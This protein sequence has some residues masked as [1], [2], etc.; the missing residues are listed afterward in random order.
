[1][2]PRQT[3]CLP[4][5]QLCGAWKTPSIRR[6]IFPV[7]RNSAQCKVNIS[8]APVPENLVTYYPQYIGRRGWLTQQDAENTYLTHKDLTVQ[9]L[10][11][12]NADCLAFQED[13]LQGVYSLAELSGA[14]AATAVAT[15]T[16]RP[17]PGDF[18]CQGALPPLS[19][20]GRPGADHHRRSLA[21]QR[22]AR[23]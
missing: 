21:A 9:L 20:A 3:L 15:P 4:T 23:R 14:P 8:P 17:T 11:N 18:V 1:M 13:L 2:L 6:A 16:L 22:S 12:E 7:N 19:A 10:Y 5:I